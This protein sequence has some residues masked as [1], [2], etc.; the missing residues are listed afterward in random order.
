MKRLLFPALVALFA[1][2]C[3]TGPY[4]GQVVDP[5]SSSSLRF[6]GYLEYPGAEVQLLVRDLRGEWIRIPTSRILSSTGRTPWGGSNWYGWSVYVPSSTLRPYWRAEG[7]RGRRLYVK[8]QTRRYTTDRWTDVYAFD[9]DIGDSS[10]PCYLLT[11]GRTVSQLQ[12]CL[13]PVTPVARLQDAAFT[14]CGTSDTTCNGRDD[15]CNGLVDDRCPEPPGPDILVP[16]SDTC[17]QGVARAGCITVPPRRAPSVQVDGVRGPAEYWGAV[18]VPVVRAPASGGKLHLSVDENRNLLVFG[19][20]VP[21]SDKSVTARVLLDFDRW[22][23]DPDI[24]RDTDRSF[25]VNLLTGAAHVERPVTA[26][27]TTRWERTSGS[28]HL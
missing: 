16:R 1:S 2:A 18:E 26:G 12:A 28:A 14:T 11:A 10:S 17:N 23:A 9:Q 25:V 3:M 4:D 15:D 19:A 7:L 20:D 8:A 27:G 6:A 13:S 5:N 21:F 22:A 24:L